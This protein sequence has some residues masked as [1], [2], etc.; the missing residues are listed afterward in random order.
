MRGHISSY[1]RGSEFKHLFAAVEPSYLRHAV[2]P[3]GGLR[4]QGGV[5]LP[6]GGIARERLGFGNKSL[7]QQIRCNSGAD[8]IVR[9]KEN[10]QAPVPP[11]AVFWLAIWGM[12]ARPFTLIDVGLERRQT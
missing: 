8:G 7:G 4:S 10:G 11:L 9:M 5:Q 3:S 6:T 2:G 1:L 12:G